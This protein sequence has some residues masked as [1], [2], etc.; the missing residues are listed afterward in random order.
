MSQ[1]FA[2]TSA[3]PTV[4]SPPFRSTIKKSVVFLHA[5]YTAIGNVPMVDSATAFIVQVPDPRLPG[6]LAFNYLVTNRHAVQPGIAEGHPVTVERY[7]LDVNGRDNGSGASVLTHV[8]LENASWEFPEDNSVDL[9][10]MLILKDFSVYDV[11]ALRAS[12]LVTEKMLK[13]QSI[14]EGDSVFFTGL[15]VQFQGEVRLEPIVRQGVLA[16]I[17]SEPITTTLG[18]RGRMYLADMH[19][20]GGNSGSPVFVNLTGARNGVVLV[21]DSYRVLGVLSGMMTESANF[22][23]KATTTF[24][25]SVGMNSGI[26]TIVPADELLKLLDSPSLQMER[27]RV[28]AETL[29]HWPGGGG[30]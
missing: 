17:P 27:D 24:D 26:S 13:E 18:S 9:A 14:G 3:S 1:C 16:M 29:K 7:S 15:F 28:L 30:H 4:P 25:G 5:Y 23:L 22:E 10:V 6:G 19:A 8:P 11:T 12:D 2:Q 21:G 20:F